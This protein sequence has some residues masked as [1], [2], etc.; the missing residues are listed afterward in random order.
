MRFFYTLFIYLYYTLILVAS[1]FNKKAN[2]WIT[3]RKHLFKNMNNKRKEHENIIWF[4]CASLGEF[5]QGRPVIEKLKALYPSKKILLTFFSPSGFDIKQNYEHADYIYYIPLDTPSNAKKFINTWNPEVV[6]FVKYEYWYNHFNV[7][8]K[9][10]I[11][12]IIIS[13]I[14]NKNQHFF[15]PYGHWFRN[16]L[17]NIDHIIVQNNESLELLKGI[18]V[19]NL[20]VGGDTRFDRV[21]D[22]SI[23]PKTFENIKRFS[24]DSLVFIAGSTW[25]K[26]ENIIADLI[27]NDIKDVK[28]IIAPHEINSQQ[29]NSFINKIKYKTILYSSIKEKDL[30]DAKVM[31][32]DKIGLLS[33]IYQ[34]GSI[35]YIGGGFGKGI[36]NILEGAV[37]G[38]PVIF[39]P[40][41]KKSA[42]A[43]ALKNKDVAFTIK[44]STELINL[45]KRFINNDELLKETSFL[46]KGFVR[47]NKGAT[48]KAL[49]IIKKLT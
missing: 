10:N 48:E 8:Y 44:N 26:D 33:H 15:K 43:I 36:H 2:S 38:M 25:K 49:S 47:E 14:F 41:Y 9:N 39:G 12:L 13:A 27:N 35:A 11:P 22:I 20:S 3:G 46:S 19:K 34:Y 18:G 17:K 40:N 23:N 45:T 5:E 1:P 21:Y 16:Q 42:E 37:F 24:Q 31:I 29:I 30:K 6:V 7:L 4:H 32:I 28:Y